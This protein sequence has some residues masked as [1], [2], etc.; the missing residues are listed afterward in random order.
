MQVVFRN[1]S[2][3]FFVIRKYDLIILQVTDKKYDGFAAIAGQ[4]VFVID[5]DRECKDA[6][7]DTADFDI[8]LVC[9]QS[10]AC[11]ES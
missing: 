11:P 10:I 2:P 4:T 5:S 1:C 7:T 6:G 8:G 3:L 9:S